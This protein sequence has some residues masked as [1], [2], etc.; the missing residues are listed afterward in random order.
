[1]QT[2]ILKNPVDSEIYKVARKN[3]MLLMREDAMF[4]AVNGEI[5][6]RE[7]YNFSNEG[8]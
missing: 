2:V 5:P 4:K 1:M 8:D 3:G 7:V 6:F